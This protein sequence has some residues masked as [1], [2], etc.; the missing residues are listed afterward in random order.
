MKQNRMKLF[1]VYPL[2]HD[3]VNS[4]LSRV[5]EIMGASENKYFDEMDLRSTNHL[6]NISNETDARSLANQQDGY[7]LSTWPVEPT[8][9][10]ILHI[11]STVTSSTE[12]LE[13][14]LAIRPDDDVMSKV[15]IDGCTPLHIAARMGNTPA[16]ER[17]CKTLVAK[18]SSAKDSQYALKKIM[19]LKSNLCARRW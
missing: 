2:I 1:T 8:N 12:I 15:D 11:A 9:R 13:F 10:S 16:L 3:I 7:C 6:I 5:Q 19:Q 17:L 14:L 4:N 18:I